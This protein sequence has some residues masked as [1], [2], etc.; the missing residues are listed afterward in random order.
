MCKYVSALMVPLYIHNTVFV[1][2]YNT[3][4]HGYIDMLVEVARNPFLVPFDTSN[5][6]N[7]L[8]REIQ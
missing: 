1:Q 8:Y 3:I 6:W 2:T 4:E 7:I 5:I